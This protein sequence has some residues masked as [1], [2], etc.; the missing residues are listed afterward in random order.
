LDKCTTG[1]VLYAKTQV[2]H[3]KLVRLF[4][5]RKIEKRYWAILNGT[6]NPAEGLNFIENFYFY[7]PKA[8]QE[9]TFSPPTHRKIMNIV[10]GVTGYKINSLVI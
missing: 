7:S 5:E 3:S 8:H 10:P 9:I 6:P 4:R 2:M 1:V